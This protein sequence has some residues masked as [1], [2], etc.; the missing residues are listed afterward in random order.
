[1]RSCCSCCYWLSIDRSQD[2]ITAASVDY[3]ILAA[4]RN[5]ACVDHYRCVDELRGAR[6]AGRKGRGGAGR[7]RRPVRAHARQGRDDR[8]HQRQGPGIQPGFA[9]PGDARPQGHHHRAPD[10]G[11]DRQ[12]PARRAGRRRQAVPSRHGGA[13]LGGRPRLG[14]LQIPQSGNRQGRG[15]AHLRA[16]RGRRG[17]GSRHLQ[18]LSGH[19]EQTEDRPQAAAGARRG[20]DTAD[21]AVVRRLS[22]PGAPEPVA[23][24]HGAAAR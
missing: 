14:R 4:G 16:A 7:E 6:R 15:Q 10:H 9:L 19:A 11:T 22:W 17:A 12:E 5:H 3:N 2:C 18:A 1:M 24:Q 8:P 23:R 20:A 13:G 21:R